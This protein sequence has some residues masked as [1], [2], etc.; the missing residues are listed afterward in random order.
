MQEGR[1]IAFLSKTLPLRKKCLSAYEREL[2]A[3][4][5]AVDKWRTYLFGHSFVIKTDHQSLKYLLEQRV[6]SMLQ[7]KWLTKLMGLDYQIVY[8]QGSEN[9]V[10]DAL[11]R[12]EHTEAQEVTCNAISTL[13]S[14]WL[15]EVQNS[16]E[17]DE[18]VQQLLIKLITNKEEVPGYSYQ[19]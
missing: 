1:P 6:T 19:K 7:Q 2:W 17:N 13:K 10:A 16:W 9:K 11:S 8:K 15:T 12:R 4:I 5:Y 18:L 14:A 3:L